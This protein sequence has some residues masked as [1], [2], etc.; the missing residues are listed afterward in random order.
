MS[1]LHARMPE[2]TVGAVSQHLRVL[3]EAGLVERR[4]S[5]KQRLYRPRVEA[6]DEVMEWLTD[7]WGGSLARLGNLAAAR[8]HRRGRNRNRRRP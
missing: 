6:L 1:D 7:M 2:V 5:G 4:A 3:Y 8:E